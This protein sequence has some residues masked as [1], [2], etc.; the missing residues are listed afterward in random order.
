MADTQTTPGT[1][2]PKDAQKSTE[3]FRDV[4]KDIW[5]VQ[6]DKDVDTKPIITDWAS[7]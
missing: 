2:P 6:S 7:I 3:A 4:P 1:Y 5:I